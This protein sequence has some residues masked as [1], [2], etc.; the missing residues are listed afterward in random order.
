MRGDGAPIAEVAIMA[1][2]IGKYLSVWCI[3]VMVG[4]F[5]DDKF[6]CVFDQ[7]FSKESFR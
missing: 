3:S 6:C 7:R 1:A 2:S 4:S 5:R